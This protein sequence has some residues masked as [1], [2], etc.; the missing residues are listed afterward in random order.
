MQDTK[1]SKTCCI[2]FQT[3]ARHQRFLNLLHLSEYPGITIKYRG[4]SFLGPTWSLI[5]NALYRISS[6]RFLLDDC[7]HASSSG[8]ENELELKLYCYP[9]SIIWAKVHSGKSSQVWSSPNIYLTP[10]RGL[11]G[12]LRKLQTMDTLIIQVKKYGHIGHLP[13]NNLKW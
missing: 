1:I 7:G 4:T 11:W 12:H 10:E 9:K 8:T 13:K 6:Y 3:N 2:C 5:S